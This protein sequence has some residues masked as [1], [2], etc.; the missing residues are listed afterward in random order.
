MEALYWMMLIT[1]I[2]VI[3]AICLKF[4]FREI[5]KGGAFHGKIIRNGMIAGASCG[6]YGSIVTNLF[7]DI[8]FIMFLFIIVLFTAFGYGQSAMIW[9]TRRKLGKDN[10][11]SDLTKK[12]W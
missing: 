8:S 9:E 11:Y 3:C 2:I 12:K 10:V 1:G 7:I 5:N 4:N 6:I